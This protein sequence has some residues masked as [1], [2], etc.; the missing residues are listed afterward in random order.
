MSN[1]FDDLARNL[2]KPMPRRRAVTVLGAALVTAA[3]PGIR[4]RPA[5]AGNLALGTVLRRY[6]MLRL[7]R[8]VLR[9]RGQRGL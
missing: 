1:L 2:A 5:Q 9:L 3:I 6:P 7:R 8:N 4:P